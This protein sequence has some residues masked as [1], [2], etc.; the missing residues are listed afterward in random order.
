MSADRLGRTSPRYDAFVVRLWR[1]AATGPC[2]RA[3]VEHVGSGARVRAA[4]VPTAWVLR[5]IVAHL[6][7]STSH[8]ATDGD[9]PVTGATPHD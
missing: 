1:E 6:R 2:L 7:A 4:A 8:D 9:R 5:Q 3:E